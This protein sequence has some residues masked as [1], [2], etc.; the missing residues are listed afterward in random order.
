VT[1]GS[2]QG[3]TPL[4]VVVVAHGLAGSVRFIGPVIHELLDRGHRVYLALEPPARKHEGDRWLRETA[5]R[6]GFEWGIVE[7]WRRDPWFVVARWVRRTDDYVRYLLI[8]A[9]RI[10]YLVRRAARRAPRSGRAL[11]R[12]A[13]LGARTGLRALSRVLSALDASV[14]TS[15]RTIRYLRQ[16]RADVVV[17]VPILMPGSTDSAYLRAAATAGI[18][19]AL[20]VPSW[21]NLS[22]KQLIRTAPDTLMVWNDTQRREAQEL[23]GIPAER[24]TVTGAQCFDHWFAWE[25]RTR[26]AFCARVGLDPARPFLLYAG[27]ALFPG[28]LTEAEF[29]RRWILDLRASGDPALR[30]VAILVRPHPK[31]VEEWLRVPFDDLDGVVVWPRAD[32]TMP[33]GREAREDYFDSIHHSVGVVGINTSAMI[34]AAIVGRPVFTVLVPEFHDSQTGTFHFEYVLDVGGGF[35]RT[36]Q[37]LDELRAQLS[38]LLTGSDDGGLDAV[39]RFV[40]TFVRPHGLDQAATPLFADAIEGLAQSGATVAHA[41]QSWAPLLRLVLLPGYARVQA[42]RARLKIA[43][44]LRRATGRGTRVPATAVDTLDDDE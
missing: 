29:A 34:E 15:G 28:T 32:R 1:T 19:S 21:D 12:L 25:P 37:S 24:V 39:R 8:G 16:Q 36:A 43:L 20:C 44:E 5:T 38:A 7:S 6:D 27:G 17:V 33:I 11:A 35:V 13:G 4:R 9:D 41:E 2:R 18:P 3:G 42:R 30:D 10:P 14:P 31:R 26:E 22:S 40:E 23:H